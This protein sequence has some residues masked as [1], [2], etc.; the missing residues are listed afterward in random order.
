MGV[1]IARDNELH[2]VVHKLMSDPKETNGNGTVIRWMFGIFGT[3]F[4]LVL[5]GLTTATMQRITVAESTLST[6]GERIATLEVR[7]QEATH[8]DNEIKIRLDKMDAKLD[9]I[10]Q[11]Q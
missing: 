11:K 7:A 6:R 4:V 9:R 8:A 5:G 1:E 2:N 3:L 10:L